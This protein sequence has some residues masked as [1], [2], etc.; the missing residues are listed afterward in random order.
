MRQTHRAGEKLF[1]DFAGDPVAVIDP[2]AG[3][4]RPAHIFVAAL[5][6][7]NFTYAEARRSEGFRRSDQRAYQCARRDWRC[8][9]GGGLRQPQA[10]LQ[11]FARV[12]VR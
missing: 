10:D 1:V 2:L 9:E 8:A 12:D 3:D 7:S 4:T 6:A 5:G 11:Q